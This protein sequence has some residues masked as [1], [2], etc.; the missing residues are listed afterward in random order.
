MPARAAEVVSSNIVGYQKVTLQEGF[1]FVAP[2]FN[3]VGGGDLDLQSIKLDVSDDEATGNDNIQILDADG[4]PVAQYYWYPAAWFGGTK[5]GWVDGDT[6]G[7]ADVTVANGLA[8]LVEGTSDCTV[9]VAGEVPTTDAET[10]TV[11]GF[12]FVGNSSPSA[13]N[14]QD[15]QIDVADADATGNDNIQIL[16]AN[17]NPVA[18]Y[19]WYPAAWFGGTKSGWVDGDTGDLADVELAPGQGVLFEA[20]DAGTKIT[21]PAAIHANE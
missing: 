6:G 12:N 8:V 3:I 5:S 10:T 9:T 14:I 7:L 4:N 21:A 1:N 16:D 11:E 17:G 15:L 13:I 2:Q 18:Q 19:Y 20:G